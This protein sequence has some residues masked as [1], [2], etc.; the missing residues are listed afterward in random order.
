MGPPRFAGESTG[1]CTG[2]KTI[3]APVA[4]LRSTQTLMSLPMAHLLS[5]SRSVQRDAGPS[6]KACQGIAV[7]EVIVVR[8]TEAALHQQVPKGLVQAISSI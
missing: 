3:S 4:W 1:G 2:V 8:S 6:K 7:A 5:R